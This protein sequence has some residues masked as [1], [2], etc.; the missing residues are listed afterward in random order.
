MTKDTEAKPVPGQINY[1]SMDKVDRNDITPVKKVIYSGAQP[2]TLIFKYLTGYIEAQPGSSPHIHFELL[3]NGVLDRNLRL[4]INETT[5][6]NGERI[7]L[8]MLNGSGAHV[9]GE[10]VLQNPA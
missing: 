1:W 6:V 3:Q 9:T 8:V 7:T 4:P 5:V 2:A 10:W